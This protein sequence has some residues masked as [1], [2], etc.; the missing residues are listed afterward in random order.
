MINPDQLKKQQESQELYQELDLFQK[1]Y[2]FAYQCKNNANEDDEHEV[3]F[4]CGGSEKLN[5]TYNVECANLIQTDNID[6]IDLTKK[7]IFC[8]I[9]GFFVMLSQ[10][11]DGN[12]NVYALNGDCINKIDN[13]PVGINANAQD[14]KPH[15]FKIK[16]V[17]IGNAKNFLSSFVSIKEPSN[18]NN[19]A[20]QV[21][22]ELDF[23]YVF[24]EIVNNDNENDI[25]EIVDNNHKQ[26][27]VIKN[28]RDGYNQIYLNK[29]KQISFKDFDDEDVKLYYNIKTGSVSN[30][31]QTSKLEQNAY[32]FGKHGLLMAITKSNNGKVNV[33]ATK[34][35]M[36]FN[37]PHGNDEYQG[38][39]AVYDASK[40]DAERFIQKLNQYNIDEADYTKIDS[41]ENFEQFFQYHCKND[42]IKI[43]D[44][45]VET[46]CCLFNLCGCGNQQNGVKQNFS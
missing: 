43:E 30:D 4:D 24:S 20:I 6:D 41:Q 12:T 17:P 36:Q 2:N 40:E 16:D 19:F 33:F 35:D 28:I 38:V 37:R 44:K 5:F 13:N 21:K 27:D 8:C 18:A 11:K 26:L 34:A 1:F 42:E 39:F 7:T 32:Y 10:G 22:N 3:E 46:D 15:V 9:R 14:I 23:K 29:G 25:E 45:E 31:H